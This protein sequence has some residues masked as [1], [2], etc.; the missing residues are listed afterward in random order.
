VKTLDGGTLTPEVLSMVPAEAAEVRRLHDH[1]R[2]EASKRAYAADWKH[3][4]SWCEARGYAALP[5]P[6]TARA[7]YR[8]ALGGHL[9]STRDSPSRP[10]SSTRNGTRATHFSGL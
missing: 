8:G 10:G 6:P 2:A 3:F 5:A 9:K 1:A 7:L 4:E